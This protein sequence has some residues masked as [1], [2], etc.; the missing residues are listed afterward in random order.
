MGDDN[1]RSPKKPHPLAEHQKICYRWLRRWHLRLC[2]TWCK[3]VYGG[4]LSTWVKYNEFFLSYLF[5]SFFENSPTGQT[6][7]RIFTLDGPK[8]QELAQG[9]AFGGFRW[10]CFP[11]WVWNP[12]PQKKNNFGAVNRRFQ[13]KRAKHWK[14]HI[15][16][17][18]ASISIKFSKW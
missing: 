10:Y 5:I 7:R 13:G 9:W 16:E 6:R 8:R 1:F 4:L 17:T 2:Q 11:F 15:I 12:P 14:F 3:S 18:T